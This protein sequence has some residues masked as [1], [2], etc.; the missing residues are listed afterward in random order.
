MSMHFTHRITWNPFT[1]HTSQPHS[2]APGPLAAVW[3]PLKSDYK[4][5]TVRGTESPFVL[6]PCS[7]PGP[8]RQY[9]R[10][11]YILVK[12]P[13]CIIPLWGQE[14]N[15]VIAIRAIVI[16]PADRL[17]RLAKSFQFQ[18]LKPPGRSRPWDPCIFKQCQEEG[19]SLHWLP[20]APLRPMVP[21]FPN[22]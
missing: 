5:E 8:L 7:F 21:L 20:S 14:S 17:E 4:S 18:W 16:L 6:M 10:T 3:K 15:I 12:I 9:S 22:L 2:Q 11:Q 19:H 13:L 1:R